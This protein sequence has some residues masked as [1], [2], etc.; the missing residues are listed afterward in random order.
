M[1]VSGTGFKGFFR[2]LEFR[3][4]RVFGVYCGFMPSRCY[5]GFQTGSFAD[6]LGSREQGTG[7]CPKGCLVELYYT[8]PQNPILSIKAPI[9]IAGEFRITAHIKSSTLELQENGQNLLRQI[10]VRFNVLE[11]KDLSML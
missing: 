3:V 5:E 1:R 11:A 6:L 9:L 4:S 8:M 7:I 10:L 2:A